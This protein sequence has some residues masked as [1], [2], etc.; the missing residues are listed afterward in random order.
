MIY[1]IWGSFFSNLPETYGS[2]HIN[3]MDRGPSLNKRPVKEVSVVGDKYMRLHIKNVIKE[4][5]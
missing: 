2:S 4:S 5:L 1:V 3:T